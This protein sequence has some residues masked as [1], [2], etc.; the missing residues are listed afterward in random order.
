MK[1][2]IRRW[3]TTG[4]AFLLG[5][6]AFI[7]NLEN[8]SAAPC[9][10]V[11]LCE[12]QVM[13]P[14]HYWSWQTSGWA[15]YCSGD[16]PYY[17][18]NGQ[19]TLGFGNN[20]TWDNSCFSVTENPFAEDVSKMDAT[21]TNWCIHSGGEDITVTL[22]CSKQNPAGPSCPNNN[23]N[24]VF[25]DLNCPVQGSPQNHCAPGTFPVCFQTWTEQCS[26]GPAF[27]TGELGVIWCNTCAQ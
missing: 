17:W 7:N 24:T 6:V 3:T 20:F 14:I 2:T 12:T 1:R 26:D 15:Y 21:I 19:S 18:N 27:C 9:D 23:F 13:T 10:G 8:L 22:G 4:L 16:H 5:A 11:P 25:H